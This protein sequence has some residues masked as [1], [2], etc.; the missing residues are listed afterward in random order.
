MRIGQTYNA[1]NRR[2]TTTHSKCD[3]SKSRPIAGHVV[4]TADDSINKSSGTNAVF[5]RS[6]EEKVVTANNVDDEFEA[7]V[8]ELNQIDVL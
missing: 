1:S 4:E 5:T 7:A 8:C 3:P 6:V 2:D